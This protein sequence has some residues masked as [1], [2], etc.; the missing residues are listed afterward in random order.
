MG[1][2]IQGFVAT[3]RAAARAALVQGAVAIPLEAAG[4]AFIPLTDALA[5]HL[6]SL[7]PAALYDRYAEFWKLSPSALL[8]VCEMS[9]E[10]R[11]AYIETDYFGGAGAQAAAAWEAGQLIQRP[12]KAR[13]GPINDALELLGV[14]RTETKDEFSVAGLDRHRRMEDWNGD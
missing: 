5:D 9:T 6:S 14:Q 2:T 8:W 3:P 1:H 12:T 13:V 7:F 4:L 10:G 11:V